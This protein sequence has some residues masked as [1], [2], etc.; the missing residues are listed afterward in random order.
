MIITTATRLRL[1]D[2]Y[3]NISYHHHYHI[4]GHHGQR[5][6][7]IYILS[8]RLFEPDAVYEIN[9]SRW[10]IQIDLINRAKLLFRVIIFSINYNEVIKVN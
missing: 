9:R 10:L 6:Y 2:G 7:I 8:M 5:I 4:I 3:N 1:D